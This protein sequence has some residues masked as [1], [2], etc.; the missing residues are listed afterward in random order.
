[1]ATAVGTPGSHPGL[2]SKLKLALDT[3]P[4]VVVMPDDFA[5]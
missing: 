5:R 2:G 4:R 3:E 1:M